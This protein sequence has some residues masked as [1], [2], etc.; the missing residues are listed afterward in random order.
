[1]AIKDV[2][3]IVP[4]N[5]FVTWNRLTGFLIFTVAVFPGDGR[6]GPICAT[7]HAKETAR[8]L[9]TGMG[10]SLSA[11][12]VL[13]GGQILHERSGSTIDVAV[14]DGRMFQP[15]SGGGDAMAGM[16]I[17]AGGPTGRAEYVCDI[18]RKASAVRRQRGPKSKRP[19]RFQRGSR[20]W[21]THCP[22][23]TWR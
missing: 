14:R 3:A 20:V 13:A 6:S 16:M 8:F 15:W 7:C 10:N 5:G 12:A 19:L 11:P 1:M 9:Q 17:G 18:E 2:I 21:C 4:E 23:N 22:E